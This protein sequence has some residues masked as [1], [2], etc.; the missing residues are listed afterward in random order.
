M[1]TFVHGVMLFFGVV[2]VNEM[3]RVFLV[4]LVDGFGWLFCC[5][6]SGG[7]GFA[8]FWVKVLLFNFWQGFFLVDVDQ[9]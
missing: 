4:L 9:R 3:L 5:W 8:V 2:V 1:F 6:L 7:L